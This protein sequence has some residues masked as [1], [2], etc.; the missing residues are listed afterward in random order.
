MRTGHAF[1]VFA[2]LYG[3]GT[4]VFVTLARIDIQP[5]NYKNYQNKEDTEEKSGPRLPSYR[6][7]ECKF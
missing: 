1:W 2:G 7:L 6:T 4:V 5:F 3:V